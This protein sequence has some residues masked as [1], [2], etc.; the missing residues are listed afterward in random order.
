MLAAL[1]RHGWNDKT[2]PVFIELFESGNLR[3]LRGQTRVRL[4]Q[5]VSSAKQVDG[6]GLT[7]I[8]SYA[9]GIGA[10][11]N[12]V[13]PINKKDGSLGLPTDLVRRAHAVGL[14]IHVWTLRTDQIF[15]AAGYGADG[16]AEFRKFRSL[17][18]DGMFTDFPEVAAR[19][20]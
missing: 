8:A 11:K 17:G 13:Q 7:A 1:D 5:L 16:E 20:D 19:R 10:E 9:D 6:P 15:L 12:L 14:L 18:V 3:A 2:A 4:I